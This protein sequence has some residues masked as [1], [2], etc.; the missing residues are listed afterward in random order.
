M[1]QAGFPGAFA[2]ALTA[3]GS[4][5]GG[6]LPPSI[7]LVLLGTTTGLSIGALFAAGIIP[8]LLVGLLLM[9]QVYLYAVKRGYG[10][11]EVPFT[12]G[13]LWGALLGAWAALII[14][15]VIV[16]GIVFG[17]FTATE[18]GAIA[19]LVAFTTGALIYRTLTRR[20]FAATLTRTV[21]IVSSVFIILAASGPFSWLLNRIGALDGLEAFLLQFAGNPVLFPVVL[22]G[23]IFVVGILL[24]PIPCVVVLGPALVKVCVAAG[25]HEIQAA[26]VLAVGFIMGAVTPPVG[27]CYFTAAAI[28]GEKIHNVARAIWPFLAVEVVVMF[29]MLFIPSITL[30]L[31]R[32]FGLL[33]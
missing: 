27:I 33:R 18:A 31:P 29:L 26:L 5:I 14:P 10:G 13:A 6:I 17:I 9:G 32:V 22:V 4:T 24:E 12:W 28:A 20:T 11:Y 23:L 16:G 2:A 3:V 30:V 1:R 8:G 19:A 15:V 21:K 7:M 25:Y